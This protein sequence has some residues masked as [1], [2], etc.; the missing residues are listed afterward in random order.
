ML[1]IK[2]NSNQLGEKQGENS[3]HFSPHQT[4]DFHTISNSHL[5]VLHVYLSHNNILD[6]FCTFFYSC[7]LGLEFPPHPPPPQR[8]P[9]L[10]VRHLPG[11]QRG[12]GD[13][14]EMPVTT[15]PPISSFLSLYQSFFLGN[16]ALT[17]SFFFILLLPVIT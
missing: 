16:L 15:L 12:Y 7:C 2:C 6:F 11:Q 9:P 10:P 5:W 1:L 4:L 13:V 17:F 14:C 8:V 3:F